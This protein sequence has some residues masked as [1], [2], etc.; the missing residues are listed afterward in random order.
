VGDTSGMG[1]VVGALLLVIGLAFIISGGSG[2]AQDLFEIVFGKSTTGASADFGTS[3]PS[4]SAQALVNAALL[5]LS[6]TGS[7]TASS[8]VYTP[9]GSPALSSVGGIPI[10]QQSN[11]TLAQGGAV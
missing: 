7:G 9:P 2:H 10:S 5:S 3:S 4:E 8:A 1:W 6:V 11:Q